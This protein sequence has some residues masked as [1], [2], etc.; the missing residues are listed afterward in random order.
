[1]PIAVIR[2]A[3]PIDDITELQAHLA[4]LLRLENVGFESIL[5]YGFRA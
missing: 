2:G 5:Q 4:T 3:T 1:M